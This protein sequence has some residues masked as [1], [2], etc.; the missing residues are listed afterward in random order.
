MEIAEIYTLFDAIGCCTFATIDGD[1]PETRI[2]R[3]AAYD[4]EGLRC[5]DIGGKPIF[6]CE[7]N[8]IN[9]H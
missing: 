4:H 3:F 2:A 9:F 8:F 5:V 1:Y 7:A 6:K